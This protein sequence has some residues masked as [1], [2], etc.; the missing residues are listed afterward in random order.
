MLVYNTFTTN[1]TIIELSSCYW[2]SLKSIINITL[3]SIIY[4]SPS[5]RYE[6]CCKQNFDFWLVDHTYSWLFLISTP[7][8]CSYDVLIC[9]FKSSTG[10]RG[11]AF[12]WYLCFCFF[13]FFFFN[14]FFYFIWKT[15]SKIHSNKIKIMG[16]LSFYFQTEVL[17]F[18]LLLLL[19]FFF[20]WLRT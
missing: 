16:D 10:S 3:L 15:I 18:W 7:C 6:K 19:F 14:Y 8:F 12:D 4:Y 11:C 13:F 2:F 20:F 9:F 1:F 17:F 5:C